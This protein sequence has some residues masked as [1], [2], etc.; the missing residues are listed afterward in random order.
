MAFFLYYFISMGLV[1]PAGPVE[2]HGNKLWSK[3]YQFLTSGIFVPLQDDEETVA[4][5]DQ[6]DSGEEL[7]LSALPDPDKY[8]GEDAD[9]DD[10][11]ADH[12]A[13]DDDAD[14]DS[15]EQSN[16]YVFALNIFLLGKVY[17]FRK[18]QEHLPIIIS[19]YFIYHSSPLQVN[20]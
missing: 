9:D 19:V 7:D 12:D 2:E 16:R 20:I 18:L 3:G 1:V 15:G 5:L 8:R 14:D 13:D 4:Y 11:D 17:L 6:D 10:D